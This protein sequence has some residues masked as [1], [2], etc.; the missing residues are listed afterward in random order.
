MFRQSTSEI[1]K[2][3]YENAS[4]N[5]SGNHVQLRL[6]LSL[7]PAANRPMMMMKFM[8]NVAAM[9]WMMS[10]SRIWA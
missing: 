9:T 5:H 8:F 2:M 1:T 7:S 10:D 3:G 6:P 4:H